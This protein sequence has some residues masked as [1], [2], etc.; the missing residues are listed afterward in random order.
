M[1]DRDIKN[2]QESY[3]LVS[4]IVD[5]QREP[6]LNKRREIEQMLDELCSAVREE[7]DEKGEA[8]PMEVALK[9]D[10]LLLQQ[11]QNEFDF[12]EVALA[13]RPAEY[14]FKNKPEDQISIAQGMVDFAK[15]LE[16]TVKRHFG[17]EQDNSPSVDGN[18]NRSL[19]K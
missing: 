12:A 13:F 9:F 15:T 1:K 5:I 6:S 10:K 8:L 3:R 14:D 2:L 19:N 11:V 18:I 7:Y 4:E 17:S 16:A